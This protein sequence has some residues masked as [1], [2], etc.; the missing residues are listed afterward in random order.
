VAHVALSAEIHDLSTDDYDCD[1]DIPE[2]E[3][4]TTPA[5]CNLG[6]WD[7]IA[8]FEGDEVG[9]DNRDH[10]QLGVLSGGLRWDTRDSQRNPYGG[11]RVGASFDAPLIQGGGKVGARFDLDASGTV[12]VPGIFHRGGDPDEENPP[13]DTLNLGAHVWMKAGTLPFTYLPNLGGSETLRGYQ[14][15]RWRDDAAWHAVLEH[16]VWVIPRGFALTPT[17]RVE[18]IGFAPFVEAG[19]VGSDGIDIFQN[20]VKA[21]YGVGLRILLER[22]APFRLDFAWSDEGFNWSA[23]F[24]Y[25]F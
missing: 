23:R 22:A 24:G 6:G 21:S 13:T 7:E 4:G 20:D 15:G 2:R 8:V 5:L 17:I 25:T 18:R 10:E 12:A 16:R 14:A 9:I 1:E 19:T 11:V 3:L